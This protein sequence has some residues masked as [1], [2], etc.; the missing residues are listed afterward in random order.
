[1]TSPRTTH[2]D[3]QRRKQLAVRLATA[4]W[5]DGL[6]LPDCTEDA[7]REHASLIHWLFGVIDGPGRDDAVHL[8]A[9]L[10]DVC[11]ELAHR[12]YKGNGPAIN[13]LQRRSA[14]V[15]KLLE[16]IR[17]EA[18][19]GSRAR[20]C[21]GEHMQD[22]EVV[23][24]GGECLAEIKEA[25]RWVENRVRAL[26]AVHSNQSELPPIRLDTDHAHSKKRAG[27]FDRFHI[28][29][30][31]EYWPEITVVGLDIKD[32]AFVRAILFQMLYVLAHELVCHAFQALRAEQRCQ[33]DE[34]C[35]WSEGWMDRL[36]F[37]LVES[38]LG[39][40]PP[41]NLPDWILNS[42]R[43]ALNAC[44]EL[45]E[46]RYAEPG[47]TLDPRYRQRRQAGREACDALH[48]AWEGQASV[49]AERRS[50]EFALRLNL[51]DQTD[52]ERDSL[53]QRLACLRHLDADSPARDQIVAACSDFLLHDSPNRLRAELDAALGL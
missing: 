9:F 13:E 30:W 15:C 37:R 43:E 27:V 5:L 20:I 32:D 11:K 42:R 17:C 4:R 48:D 52:R 50:L 44:R 28:N 10:H 29:G 39:E 41:A 1:M 33:A 36:S 19:A 31:T 8:D 18:C 34:K 40:D 2:L 7:A 22:D 12:S 51:H 45:H 53:T 6:A 46:A 23:R 16:R 24:A 49:F 3:L 14:E 26:Y 21:C 25:T 38:W 47:D 35:S